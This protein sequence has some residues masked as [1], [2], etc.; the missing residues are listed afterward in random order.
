MVHLL[1][2]NLSLGQ[3]GGIAVLGLAMAMLP[4]APLGNRY[5]ASA[6]IFLLFVILLSRNIA[7]I[8]T[9]VFGLSLA[10]RFF[11]PG[12]AWHDQPWAQW[13]SI[14]SL[15]TGH[16]IFVASPLVGMSMAGYLPTGDLFGGVF[17]ALGIVSYWRVWHVIV[18]CLLV[19]PVL[20]SP[21][22]A[23]VMLFMGTAFF[24]PFCDYTTAG[25]TLEISY[26]LV[27][28]AILL[29]RSGR[30]TES[31][32]LFAFAAMFRQPNIMLVP[33]VFLV[34]WKDR[35]YYRGMIF[36][37]CLFLFGGFFILLDLRGAYLWLFRFWDSFLE[38]FYNEN[39]G[40]SNNYSISSIPHMFGIDDKVAWNIW[41]PAYLILVLT[42]V[43]VLLFVAYRMDATRKSKENIIF[44]GVLATVFVYIFSRGYAQYHYVAA[45]A[46]PLAAFQFSITRRNRKTIRYWAAGLGMFIVWVGVLPLAW[47]MTARMDAAILNF[48][49]LPL[50]PV[51]STVLMGADGVRQVTPNVDGVNEH[52]QLYWLNQSAEFTFDPPKLLSAMRIS[53]DHLSILR[54]KGV[55][56][57]W[58]SEIEMRGIIEQGEVSYSQDGV[59]FTELQKL[60]NHITYSAYPVTFPLS[61]TPGPVRA[62]RIHA[63]KLYLNQAQWML[64]NVEFFGHR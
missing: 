58:A 22:A 26:A 43:A 7:V 48:R 45:T 38:S 42:S 57:P 39:H 40:L 3:A 49:A 1:R 50:V 23:T 16:N 18:M 36:G 55:D 44:L 62:I 5:S 59:H 24:F 4:I 11:F 8:T 32:P 52:R 29:Y 13:Y 33:F 34:L 20:A 12:S 2:P 6:V 37:A 25:G 10:Y 64:G 63:N 19:L 27:F 9:A 60:T 46:I 21:S 47:F 30:V 31:L 17:I 15:L 61:G 51:A 56:L 54:V 14:S 41:P 35:D 28:G 53:G